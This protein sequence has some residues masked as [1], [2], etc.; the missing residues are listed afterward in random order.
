M[1]DL[2]RLR[3][4][5]REDPEAAA[6]L[7][8]ESLRRADYDTAL[9]VGAGV[10]DAEKN[11]V[12]LWSLWG[13]A[14][15]QGHPAQLD[16]ASVAAKWLQEPGS[17]HYEQMLGMECSCQEKKA[18]LEYFR[19]KIYAALKIPE[20][21]L[22]A[23]DIE[24]SDTP[25]CDEHTNC[26][27]QS[28]ATNPCFGRPRT[29][30][31][32]YESIHGHH[33][34]CPFSKEGYEARRDRMIIW[35]WETAR[36]Y[37]SVAVGF[38]ALLAHPDG[39]EFIRQ[40]YPSI[41]MRRRY[42]SRG[43]GQGHYD[44]RESQPDEP[45]KVRTLHQEENAESYHLC[46]A[47]LACAYA[48]V[49]DRALDEEEV[50]LKAAELEAK[51][52]V[53]EEGESYGRGGYSRYAHTPRQSAARLRFVMRYY[54]PFFPRPSQPGP[55]EVS[56][57]YFPFVRLP[58]V[59]GGDGRLEL[60]GFAHMVF[61]IVRRVFPSLLA[62]QIVRV[63]PM[64]RPVGQVFFNTDFQY[65][66]VRPETDA[67]DIRAGGEGLIQLQPVDNNADASF[68]EWIRGTLTG[69]SSIGIS[70]RG[71]GRVDENGVVHDPQ[72]DSFSLVPQMFQNQMRAL[73]RMADEAHIDEAVSLEEEE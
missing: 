60:R 44:I 24:L 17:P 34:P 67:A 65:A 2:S 59:P 11:A 37:E 20:E 1:T 14:W 21:Y 62:D 57:R 16:Y 22:A 50:V 32:E 35:V 10:V 36:Q 28:S 4:Y 43:L 7:F 51:R 23:Q 19:A 45:W 52:H 73:N 48:L 12:L 42:E 66:D 69:G 58:L 26:D 41:P 9:T 70:S 29:Q 3:R 30:R 31:D 6:L 46:L 47:Q 8:R 71:T 55:I 40:R 61:P 33:Y 49:G 53:L 5:W 68:W 56:W 27:E 25:C 64:A 38:R 72:I 18:D 15:E 54:T 39:A 63:E 13:R